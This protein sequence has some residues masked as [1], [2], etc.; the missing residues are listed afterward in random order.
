MT[1]RSGPFKEGNNIG[2]QFSVT[3]K[4]ELLTGQLLQQPV[5]SLGQKSF[6]SWTVEMISAILM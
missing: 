6:P 1:L 5:P 4:H 2:G 3:L